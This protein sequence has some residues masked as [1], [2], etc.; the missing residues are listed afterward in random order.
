MMQ[1][2]SPPESRPT[3]VRVSASALR[4]NL[5]RA[6]AAAAGR[7]VWAVVKADAYGH[8]LDAALD[9]FE[10]ADGLALVER[11][12]A[13]RL[14]ALGWRKP[15]LMLEGPFCP[16][17]VAW[18]RDARIALVA[19]C[20]RQL[21]WIEAQAARPGPAL[22]V[23]VKLNS[24]MN[25]LGFADG[26][27]ARAIARLAACSVVGRVG[28][29]THFANADVAGGTGRPQAGFLAACEAAAAA[30]GGPAPS[31][32]F[33]VSLANSAALLDGCAGDE[34]AGPAAWVRPGIALYGSS[35]FAGRSAASLGLA[36]AMR[37]DSE[38][39][40]VQS[41][42]PGDA[43]GY[44]GTFVADRPMRIG[45]VACG[46]ADGY[47]RHAPTGTP[48]AVEGVVTRTVGRVSMDMLA[49]DL[50]PVPAARPGSAVELWGDAVSIDAVAA[51]AGT[52]G[53]E[54]MCAVAPRVRRERLD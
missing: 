28:R 5:G 35:P 17:D 32:T 7:R 26:E 49:V 9:G 16:D 37:L 41:L 23:W 21:D 6:L 27:W 12:Q 8:G 47:P 51:A 15:V 50:E 14:R 45:I 39:L 52:I 31:E 4:A 13:S 10:Q 44:G 43:V 53:Y 11:A 2:T 40:A 36:A 20:A 38:L 34:G 18:A 25:R 42:Q 19:H 46:Y 30:T 24:G 54:L 3:R 29:M 1:P 22:E 33:P 48:V